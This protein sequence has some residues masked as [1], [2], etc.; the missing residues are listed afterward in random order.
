MIFGLLGGAVPLY[1]V[2][3][4]VPV[5]GARVFLL[6][7]LIFLHSPWVVAFYSPPDLPAVIFNVFGKVCALAATMMSM[8][9]AS[10]M[11]KG[12]QISI[13]PSASVISSL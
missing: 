13:G 6:L 4:L 8:K 1:Y 7:S 2:V 5:C 9:V 11:K 10:L 12:Y 3:C